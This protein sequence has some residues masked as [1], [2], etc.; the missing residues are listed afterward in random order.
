[1]L[2]GGGINY[3]PE[4]VDHEAVY[5]TIASILQGLRE[6]PYSNTDKDSLFSYVYQH[7]VLAPDNFTRLTDAL[8]QSCLWRAANIREMDYRSSTE[9]SQ[10]FAGILERLI[11]ENAAGTANAALDLLMGIA[12]GKIQLEKNVLTT[13]ISKAAPAYSGV[14]EDASALLGF[15]NNKYSS[16]ESSEQEDE[17]NL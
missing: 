10:E 14:N 11:E 5:L 4:R 1:M 13:L 9:L 16:A 12:T 2:F 6:K 7:A 17:V 15:I 3:D 8:L